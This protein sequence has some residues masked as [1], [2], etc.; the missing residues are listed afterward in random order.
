LAIFGVAAD[1]WWAMLAPAKTPREILARMHAVLIEALDDPAV[2]QS[3]S[4]Q[5]LVYRLSSP[6][7][8]GPFLETEIARWARVIKDNKI[9][10][11]G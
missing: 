11:A 7:E 6:Q 9:V 10:L 3:L 2:K 8:F 5:G 4:G 1:T